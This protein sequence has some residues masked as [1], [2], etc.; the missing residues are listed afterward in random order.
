MFIKLNVVIGFTSEAMQ[1]GGRLA[2]GSA[3]SP[4][5]AAYFLEKGVEQQMFNAIEDETTFGDLEIIIIIIIGNEQRAHISFAGDLILGGRWR[6][7][8]QK[9]FNVIH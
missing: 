4:D 3:L 6:S 7:T 9:L 2:Q 1:V 8:I 5:C